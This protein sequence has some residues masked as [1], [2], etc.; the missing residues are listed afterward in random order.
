M[1]IYVEIERYVTVTDNTEINK[2]F[3]VL[4]VVKTTSLTKLKNKW[5]ILVKP[6][7]LM[8]ITDKEK[9]LQ[10]GGALAAYNIED[11]CV[12]TITNSPIQRTDTK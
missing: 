8:R 5:N 10:D 3:Q 1:V 2:Y 6:S 11:P 4:V 12:L 9:D 7:M